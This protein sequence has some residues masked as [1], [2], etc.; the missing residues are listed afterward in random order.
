MK[1]DK[2]F[3]IVQIKEDI[4]DGSLDKFK[5]L[6]SGHGRKTISIFLQ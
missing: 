3:K 2:S 4:R 5:I 6:W 1:V